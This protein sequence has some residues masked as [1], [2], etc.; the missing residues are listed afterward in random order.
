MIAETNII[1]LVLPEAAPNLEQPDK[2]STRAS[3]E[4]KCPHMKQLLN[5]SKRKT[6][7]Q[8]KVFKES[9]NYSADI[10]I[11]TTNDSIETS[12]FPDW[13]KEKDFKIS[14]TEI[15]QAAPNLG[16]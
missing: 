11:S 10:F 4:K 13:L 14:K 16:A 12:K 15:A 1:F 9:F 7:R 3:N 5:Q 6:N 8:S 2:H